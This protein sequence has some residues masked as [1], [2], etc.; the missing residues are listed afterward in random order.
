M[1]ATNYP[2]R[3]NCLDEGIVSD[4]KRTE[5]GEGVETGRP[6]GV[7]TGKGEKKR[8]TTRG[9]KEG[10]PRL[11]GP[12]DEESGLERG[13][14]LCTLEEL[15]QIRTYEREDESEDVCS[16][17]DREETTKREEFDKYMRF[18]TT[19]RRQRSAEPSYLF[20]PTTEGDRAIRLRTDRNRLGTENIGEECRSN[21]DSHDN[22]FSKRSRLLETAVLA[23]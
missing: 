18:V 5:E 10:R 23:T 4:C 15:S 16:F 8:R 7:N 2:R 14:P 9:G 19:Y 6:E 3:R 1:L 20:S 22:Q 17:D 13:G 12:W 11:P 21:S